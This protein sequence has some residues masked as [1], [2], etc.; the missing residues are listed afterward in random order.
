MTEWGL[1]IDCARPGELA[2]F[3]ALALGH[4][5]LPPPEGFASW[6]EWLTSVGEPE[7]SWDDGAYLRDPSGA[8]P[9]I[10]FLKVPECKVVKH[11]LHTAGAQY[12]REYEADGK[13]D[14]VQMTDP[15]GNEFDVV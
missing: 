13:P 10:S 4:E 14:H 1:T 11:R 9:T 2:E 6:P 5:P 7:E 12:V 3:W 8:G 15:E